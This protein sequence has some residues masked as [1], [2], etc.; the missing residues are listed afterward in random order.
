MKFFLRDGFANVSIHASLDA[1][2]PITNQSLS[3]QSDDG[4]ACS[5]K[6]AKRGERGEGIIHSSKN[7]SKQKFDSTLGYPG[8]G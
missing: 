8:E 1:G 3:C 4:K 2:V 6:R 7:N 5:G